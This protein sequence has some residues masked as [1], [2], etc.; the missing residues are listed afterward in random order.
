MTDT[1]PISTDDLRDWLRREPPKAT[2]FIVTIYGDVVAPR[3]GV[4][5]MGSLIDCCAVH[6]INE[7]LA[8]TAVSRLVASGRLEGQRVGR[9]SY[10]RL[11]DAAQVE[12]G[13]A[14]RIL[15]SPPP[16]A[17]GWRLA[18][19]TIGPGP[20]WV[21]VGGGHSIAPDRSDLEP[22]EGLS[23]STEMP[24][25]R[26]ALRAFV[27]KHWPLEEIAGAYTRFLENFEP[28]LNGL[29]N[30]VVDNAVALA[31]RLR[32]VHL[33]RHAALRDPRLPAFAL[34]DGWP[35]HHARKVFVKA[36]LSLSELGDEAAGATFSDQ[37]GALAVETGETAARIRRL[38]LE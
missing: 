11:S 7:S 14:A 30:T 27:V 31:L 38:C 32:L 9:R 20:G 33:Y 12:F 8:R 25:D 16:E 17:N 18:L 22:V 3:G 15:Y 21:G 24:E 35:G 5:W 36:Y 6:G 23:L 37:S 29:T 13:E 26:E 1:A 10:Y 34:P 28:I 19:H 2:A 4:L